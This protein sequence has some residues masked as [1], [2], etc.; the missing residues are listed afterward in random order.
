MI[1]CMSPSPRVSVIVC[2]RNRSKLL[3]EACESMLEM[4]APGSEWELL[5]V[6]N[7]STDDTLELARGIERTHPERVRVMI[8]KEVG[9]SATR[10]A[11]IGA[12]RGEILAF[13]DDDA[14]PARDWLSG[15]ADALSEPQILCAGGPVE[16]L[17]QGELPEWLDDR[18]LPY[19]TV[20]D[21]GPETL[22]LQ[23]NEYPRGANIAYR[24]AAFERFGLFSPHLGRKGRSLT[25]CEEIE[26]C[27]RIE[28]GG[29]RIVYT[30]AARIRHWVDAS[31]ITPEWM[32]KRFAAQGRSEAII[33]YQHA[34]HR[35]LRKGLRVYLTNAKNTP[36][37]TS[38]ADRLYRRCTRATLRAFFLACIDVPFRIP[39]YKPL[40]ESGPPKPWLPFQ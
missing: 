34:G 17:F 19:L 8:E 20:W 29:G 38:E 10:N 27:L 1:H 16:P 39:R 18:F 5:I 12:A 15:I 6:D 30:P 11:G 3:E 32:E 26:H 25:S 4:E 2:T 36:E 24:R 37:G 9:L 14:F 28:R 40:P 22:P 23:Y 13:L 31:R 7:D 33:H 21:K 35:G